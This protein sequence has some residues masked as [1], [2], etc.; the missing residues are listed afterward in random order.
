LRGGGSEVQAAAMPAPTQCALWDRP[1]LL[2][3]PGE[4]PFELVETYLDESHLR[5]S[6]LRC[7]ECGQLYFHE[8]YEEIDWVDGEDPQYSTFIPVA[9][10]AEIERLKAAS[11]PG[12]L[13]FAPR[14]Q[15]DFPK[16]A[17]AP[18]V[19]WVRS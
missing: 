3:A 4:R 19:R 15:R 10:P 1:E 2:L 11:S 12:L 14:L 13:S 16:G 7:R 18:T 9:D 8:F 5:R 6:L 17:S